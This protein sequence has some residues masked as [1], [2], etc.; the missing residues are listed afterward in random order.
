MP[1]VYFTTTEFLEDAKSAAKDRGMPGI[2]MIALPADKYYRARATHEE[3]QPVASAV[4]DQMVDDLVRPLT[5]EETK[6]SQVQKQKENDNITVK[7]SDYQDAYQ[8][9]NDLFL[10]SHW[11]DGLPI[12]PPSPASTTTTASAAHPSSSPPRM[13]RTPSCSP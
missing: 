11:A 6:P 1:G 7:G 12:V 4:I 9:V 13:G 8:K 3:L 2:R 5:A 10:D